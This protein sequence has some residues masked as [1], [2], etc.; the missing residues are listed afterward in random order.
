M[1]QI[2]QLLGQAVQ[3]LQPMQRIENGLQTCRRSKEIVAKYGDATAFVQH[4]TVAIQPVLQ[5]PQRREKMILYKAPSQA[6]MVQAYGREVVELIVRGYVMQLADASGIGY[7]TEQVKMCASDIVSGWHYLTIYE[8]A[9]ALKMA[10]EGR[11]RN[12]KTDR[13]LATMYGAFSAVAISDCIAAFVSEVRNPLIDRYEEEQRR[14]QIEQS[15]KHS[16]TK[17]WFVEKTFIGY[18]RFF[19][20]FYLAISP[21]LSNFAPSKKK[22]NP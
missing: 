19:N 18:L 8:I 1:K 2:N 17:K 7:T 20:A 11:F 3:Q 9:A 4:H 21:F 5:D 16:V 10:R 15:S 6:A 13:N 22:F 12:P 14:V